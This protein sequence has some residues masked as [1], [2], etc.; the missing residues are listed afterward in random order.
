VAIDDPDGLQADN[1]RYALLDNAARPA[2]LVVTATGDLGREAFYV[3]QAL[4][5]AAGDPYQIVGASGAQLAAWDEA[6]LSSQTAVVLLSTRGLERRGREAL[7][8]YA[9]GGGGVLIAAGPDVDGEVVAD[10][11][12]DDALLR[13]APPADVRPALRALA[14]ADARHPVFQPFGANASSLGLVKFQTVARIGGAGCQTLA[15]FTSGEPAL[16]DCP[17]GDGRA[18]V[19]ASDL[20]NR[21]ND[22]PLHATFVPF[23]HEAIRYLAGSHP[24][25][26]DYLVGDAPAGLPRKPGIVTTAAEPGARVSV[27]SRARPRQV[28]INVDPREGDPTRISA[29]EFQN[30]VARLKDVGAIEAR[31][32]AVQQEDRQHLWRFM[33]MAMLAMLAIEGV[34][35]SRTA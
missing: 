30:A 20:N 11:L 18:L 35:A 21:W 6:R 5:A 1:V 8:A 9:R 32:E 25:G 2:L 4:A 22:F 26:A 19:I 34:V 10:V 33:L 12:G 27:T 17:A 15:R 28:A 31:V 16:I 23:L 13:I 7:A 3:Q 29:E 14:P 24:H